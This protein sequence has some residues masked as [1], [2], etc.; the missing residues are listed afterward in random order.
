MLTYDLINFLI[1]ISRQAK[2]LLD[3]GADPNYIYEEKGVSPMHLA[4]GLG[5]EPLCLL[6]QYNGDPNIR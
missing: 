3:R 5:V 2:L 4:A 1:F 6:L